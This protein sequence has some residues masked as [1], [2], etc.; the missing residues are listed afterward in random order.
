MG[1]ASPEQRKSLITGYD[2]LTNPAKMGERFKFM[3]L[4]QRS[5]ADYVPAG[6][7]PLTES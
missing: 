4:H 6:F 5:Q 1:N 7:K 2:L 3:A